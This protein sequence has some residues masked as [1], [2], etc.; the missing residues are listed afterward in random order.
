LHSYLKA[1]EEGVVAAQF[2]V[3]LAHLEGYA[4]EKNARS[5]YLAKNG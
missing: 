4:V 1:A 2:I 3:G 5:A